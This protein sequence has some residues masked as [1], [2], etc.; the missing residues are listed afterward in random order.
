MG[1]L[2]KLEEWFGL[3]SVGGVV[4]GSANKEEGFGVSIKADV[5]LLNFP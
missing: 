4:E 5:D 2:D 3:G 1:G